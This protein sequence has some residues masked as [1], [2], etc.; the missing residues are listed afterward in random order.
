MLV[1]DF[2]NDC[3]KVSTIQET[4]ES[5]HSHYFSKNIQGYEISL[6]TSRDIS[7]FLIL[8]IV[9]FSRNDSYRNIKWIKFVQ[10]DMKNLRN[11]NGHGHVCN[12]PCLNPDTRSGEKAFRRRERSLPCAKIF[13]KSFQYL[14][15]RAASKQF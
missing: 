2:R 10:Y 8:F 5:S 4:K 9:D 13:T 12:W 7:L 15:L 3:E 14:V 11:C 6:I 1:F